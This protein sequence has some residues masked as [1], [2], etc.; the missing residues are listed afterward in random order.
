VSAVL[1]ALLLAGT[2]RGTVTITGKRAEPLDASRAVV[3]LEGSSAPEAPPAKSVMTT[4]DKKFT[5]E[6]LVL[7]AGSG[8]AFP[9]EDAIKHNAFS[10]SEGNRFDVGLY[11]PGQGKEVVLR[12][13]GVVRVYCNV[14]PQMAA[15]VVVTP[16]ALAARAKADGSFEI[17]GVPPG[18]YELKAWDERGGTASVSVVVKAD[19]TPDVPV[20]LDGSRFKQ[21]PHLDKNGRSYEERG[22]TEYP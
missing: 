9:N 2:V 13:P 22:A 19:G 4:R 8:V 15:V 17:G 6:V 12:E 5:P 21:R 14:H 1:A 10:S 7:P 11:G 16:T 18:A 20:T 3:W